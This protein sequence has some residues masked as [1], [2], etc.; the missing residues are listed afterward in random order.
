M[1]ISF[2]GLAVEIDQYL[3]K[4]EHE[5]KLVLPGNENN[6]GVTANAEIVW[7]CRDNGWYIY[8]FKF[9]ELGKKQRDIL[10]Y[11]L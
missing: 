8:G 10:Q 7:M 11:Y 9:K 6:I 4:S 2:D 3:P 1:N 5:I